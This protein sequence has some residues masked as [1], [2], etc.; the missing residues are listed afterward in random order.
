[1]TGY[2]IT[3]HLLQCEVVFNC[4]TLSPVCSCHI[5][6]MEGSHNVKITN[7]SLKNMALEIVIPNQYYNHEKI[8]SR[9]NSVNAY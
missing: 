5:N 1:M 3:V 8:R 2:Q 6:R 4:T 9:L 7:K